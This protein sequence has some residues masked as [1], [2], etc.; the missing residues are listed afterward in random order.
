MSNYRTLG[1][2]LLAALTSGRLTAA[3]QDRGG[4][5]LPDTTALALVFIVF[6]TEGGAQQAVNDLNQGNAANAAHIQ[7]YAVVQRGQDGK[8]N[9]QDNSTRDAEPSGSP[10]AENAVNGVVAQWVASAGNA[11]SQAGVSAQSMNKMQNLLKPGT[12]AVVAVT[13]EP[14][15][16]NVV[17]A[18]Q[19]QRDTTQVVE[20]NVAPQR[21]ANPDSRK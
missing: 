6:P 21:A 14:Y 19:Q 17:T 20:A 9:L 7:D 3:A 1:L 12:S 18:L 15:L 13:L 4:A 2:V 5:P 16:P 10:R 8:V 11:E